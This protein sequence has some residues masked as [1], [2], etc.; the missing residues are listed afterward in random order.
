VRCAIK[1]AISEVLDGLIA[2]FCRVLMLL[3]GLALPV[4]N[5]ED[6]KDVS[7]L[8]ADNGLTMVTDEFQGGTT[9]MM[10]SSNVLTN[11]LSVLIP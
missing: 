1:N 3:M 2:S 11:W 6:A 5:T 8:M 4:V 9:W 7:N 10:L